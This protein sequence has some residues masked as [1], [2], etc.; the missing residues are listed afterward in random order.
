V[1]FRTDVSRPVA[2]PMAMKLNE[3]KPDEEAYDPTIY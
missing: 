2:T 3:R 1:K